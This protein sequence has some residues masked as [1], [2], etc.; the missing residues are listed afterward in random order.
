MSK[1]QSKMFTLRSPKKGGKSMEV[2][3][4]SKPVNLAV[5]QWDTQ[6]S[7][8]LMFGLSLAISHKEAPEGN[9]VVLTAKKDIK[10]GDVIGHMCLIKFADSDVLRAQESYEIE[11]IADMDPE[12]KAKAAERK[13]RGEAGKDAKGL[14]EFGFDAEQ[15]VAALCK[16]HSIDEDTALAIVEAVTES[17]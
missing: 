3:G 16:K 1:L 4:K 8:N 7:Q 17:K 9:A 2:E 11:G 5:S 12:G 6:A 13:I 14:F 15:V 10:K